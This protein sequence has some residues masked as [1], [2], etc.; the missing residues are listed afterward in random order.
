VQVKPWMPLRTRSDRCEII[1]SVWFRREDV[2]GQVQ[3][4][5]MAVEFALND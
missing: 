5:M 3:Y 1:G 2:F 4:A